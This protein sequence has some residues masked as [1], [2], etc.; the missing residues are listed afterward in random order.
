MPHGLTIGPTGNIWLTDV[1]LHQ[2]FKFTHD[3]RLLSTW[4]ERGV[5]GNDRTHFAMPTD[6]AVWTDGSFYV[7]DGSENAR[8]VKFA[9]NGQ[10]EFEWGTP[11]S[12]PGQFKLP[13]GIHIDDEG[14]VYVADRGN[15][16]VQVFTHDGRF[17]RQWQGVAFGRPSRRDD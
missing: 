4:G 1:A 9:A 7:T 14:Q 2:V 15:S 11:G 6:V 13:H 12:G 3:R 17:L 8:V 10:Y 5:S 16:R